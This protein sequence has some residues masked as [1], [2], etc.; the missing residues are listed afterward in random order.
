MRKTYIP[1]FL[2]G[3]CFFSACR[4]ERVNNKLTDSKNPTSQVLR[5]QIEAGDVAR[6]NF[7]A[8]GYYAASQGETHFLHWPEKNPPKNPDELMVLPA[9]VEFYS[10][11]ISPTRGPLG[12]D[13]PPHMI[14][15]NFSFK[16]SHPTGNRFWPIYFSPIADTNPQ[17]YRMIIEGP[18]NALIEGK[19]SYE[20]CQLNLPGHDDRAFF[21]RFDS[22]KKREEIEAQA[23]ALRSVLSASNSEWPTEIN[24]TA[25]LVFSSGKRNCTA[26]FTDFDSK[27]GNFLLT[28]SDTSKPSD[29][30]EFDGKWSS[31]RQLVLKQRG[32]ASEWSLIYKDGKLNGERIGEVSGV[33]M[34]I[35]V[36]TNNASAPVKK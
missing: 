14:G 26:K 20:Y 22:P 25:F 8:I 17:I 15:Y 18:V 27:T 4:E 11:G 24:S 35:N 5:N 23:E 9:D 7:K 29:S 19:I 6:M 10:V 13:L 28:I 34:T 1:I 30:I 21:F 36:S 3:L 32:D 12:Y 31:A 33:S 16:S 2:C